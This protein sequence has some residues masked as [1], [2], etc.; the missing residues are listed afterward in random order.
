MWYRKC[1]TCSKELVCSG[2]NAF[3]YCVN[4]ELLN[5]NCP[6]CSTSGTNNPFYGKHSI[7]ILHPR[8]GK[9]WDDAHKKILSDKFRGRK[10]IWWMKAVDTEHKNNYK[11]KEY[12][13]SDGRK[14]MLQGYEPWTVDYLIT[15]S[16]LP[17]NIILKHTEKPVIEYEW[18][19]SVRKYF[20]D[21]F[22]PI[23][24]TIVETKSN[25]TW[26]SNMDKNMAKI[27]A[28]LKAG[29]DVRVIVWGHY[30]QLISDITYQG[31]SRA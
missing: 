17:E 21:C 1:P 14:E 8:Y 27:S 2:K 23:S 6:S 13:F 5:R 7:G 3:K 4:A 31:G 28:S 30:H 20:P 15:S 11:R 19:G 24:N 22:I 25:W 9:H 26:Q 16:I 10:N 18:S 29:F 12:I